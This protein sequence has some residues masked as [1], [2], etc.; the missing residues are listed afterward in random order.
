M[1]SFGLRRTRNWRH[2]CRHRKQYLVRNCYVLATRNH[3]GKKAFSIT[4]CVPAK[5]TNR[6][7]SMYVRTRCGRDCAFDLKT[8]RI[9]EKS[10]R[11]SGCRC[12]QQCRCSHAAQWVSSVG[13]WKGKRRTATERRGYKDP[14]NVAAPIGRGGGCHCQ[15]ESHESFPSISVLET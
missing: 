13:S 14:R 8:G 3:T 6:N 11:W 5:A 7:G 1:C 12:F 9:R 2:E 10:H 4:C 15:P